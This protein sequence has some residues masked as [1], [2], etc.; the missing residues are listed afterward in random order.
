MAVTK[1]QLDSN[2]GFSI[3]QTTI[4]DENRNAKDF[5]TLHMA[6]SNFT[7]SSSTRYLSLIHI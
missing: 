5:H 3:G 1:E 6:N 7:D 2:G 4:F